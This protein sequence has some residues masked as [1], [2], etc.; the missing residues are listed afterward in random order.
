[1]IRLY[2]EDE[3]S[4]DSDSSSGSYDEDV[5]EEDVAYLARYLHV[6]GL[7]ETVSGAEIEFYNDINE[8]VFDLKYQAIEPRL[9]NVGLWEI[10]IDL[11]DVV[12][13]GAPDSVTAS[14]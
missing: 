9:N 8:D 3:D 7:F 12:L 13:K 4:S 14:E 1:M 6:G 11:S 5:Y 2:A 10:P